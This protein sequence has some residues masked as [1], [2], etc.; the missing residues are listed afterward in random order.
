MNLPGFPGI[1]RITVEKLGDKDF[2][3][4][5]SKLVYEIGL[6]K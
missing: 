1:W 6:F 4:I 2:K 3:I 5:E